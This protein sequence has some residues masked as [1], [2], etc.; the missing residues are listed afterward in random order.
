MVIAAAL[1]LIAAAAFMF[2]GWGSAFN[3]LFRLEPKPWP[4]TV[5]LGMAGVVFIGGILNLARLAYP[6]ALLMVAVGSGCP[7][8]TAMR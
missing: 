7:A 6:I 2:F 4:T 5:A 8:G 3:R 1:L